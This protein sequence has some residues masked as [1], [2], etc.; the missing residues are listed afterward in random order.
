MEVRQKKIDDLKWS[1]ADLLRSDPYVSSIDPS[2]IVFLAVLVRFGYTHK[3]KEVDGKTKEWIHLA[4]SRNLGTHAEIINEIYK[5]FEP[6][7]KGLT[8]HTLVGIINIFRETDEL[9]ELDFHHF[10]EQLVEFSLDHLARN[11]SNQLIPAGLKELIWGLVEMKEN[12]SYSA[13]APFSLSGDLFINRPRNLSIDAQEL[14]RNLCA[15]GKIRSLLAGNDSL[16]KI[17]NQDPVDCWN[18]KQKKYDLIVS[19]PPFGLK[20]GERQ[21]SGRFGYVRT[22]ESFLIEKGLESLNETGKLI[23]TI[24]QSF[25]FVSDSYS[26]Q[27]KEY[28]VN[29]NYLE[30]VISLPKNV[31]SFTNI[32]TA[33]IVI[34]KSKDN[35]LVKFIDGTSFVNKMGKSSTINFE[36]IISEFKSHE[37]SKYQK[38]VQAGLIEENN[39]NLN[40]SRYVAEAIEGIPLKQFLTVYKGERT[41][42]NGLGKVVKIK[43]LKNT[44]A[45]FQLNIEEV[46]STDI[47][48]MQR[49]I[50][51]SCILIAARFKTCKP[52]YFEY[53]GESIF[54][55]NNIFA[56]IPDESKVSFEYLIYLLHTSKV[57]TQIESL[58]SGAVTP[59]ISAQDFLRVKVDLPNYQDQSKNIEE[60]RRIFAEAQASDQ[61][62]LLLGKNLTEEIERN[63]LQYNEE[64]REKQHCIRQHLKNVVDSISVINTFMDR[65][66]GTISKDDVINPIR[67]ITVAQRLTALNNSLKSLSLEI[68]NLTNDELYD[69]TEILEIRDIIRECILELGDAK[70]FL[71]QES[72][73]DFALEELGNTNPSISISKRSFKELF[74]N[75]VMNAKLHGFIKEDKEYLIKVIVT[76]EEDKLKL[77]IVNDGK[78][79]AE[80]ISKQLGVKGKKAGSNA[81]SGIGVWKVFEIAKQYDFEC[82]IIDL[83]GDEFPVGWEF[84]FGIAEK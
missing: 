1:I 14:S 75:I 22:I 71:V 83:P 67:N 28:L 19:I 73:D 38:H 9:N 53:K 49:Q 41:R 81:G 32:N 77:S 64:L 11:A 54:I 47:T 10:V 76:I 57:V 26:V 15:L 8:E 69:K 59:F 82:K 61:S 50:S 18:L 58:Q 31:F 84:K 2:L 33:V 65:Q 45:D 13:Y 30:A 36:G 21:I 55:D 29:H 62:K 16:T 24:P 44:I 56:V 20:I 48:Q 72:F 68:D 39:L 70:G 3:I 5:T 42:E 66:N 51:Q 6:S 12:R 79:F 34:S 23:L 35:R 4:I 63:R 37:N 74:N 80:G 17:L 46:E 43:D 7:I 27:L 60:Q 25:L 52:T 40:V 78:P